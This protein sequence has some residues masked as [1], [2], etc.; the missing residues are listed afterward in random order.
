MKMPGQP[1]WLFW[2]AADLAVPDE[3]GLQTHDAALPG[4]RSAQAPH[5]V[6]SHICDVFYYS[7]SLITHRHFLLS[8]TYLHT[9][10]I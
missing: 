5:D 9:Q 8:F 3:P 10:E 2:W 7:S 4:P 6:T 1:L